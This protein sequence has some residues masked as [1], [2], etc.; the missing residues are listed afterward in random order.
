MVEQLLKYIPTAA[1]RDLLNSHAHEMESFARPDRFL[2]EMSRIPRYS[3]RLKSL[4][5]KKTLSDR[6]D[7]VCPKIEAVHFSCKELKTSKKLRKVLEVVLAFGNFMNR[8][9]RGNA[10]GFRLASLNKMGDT[11]SSSDPDINLL[12][13]LV[14]TLETKFPDVLALETEL[15]H[16]RKASKVDFKEVEKEFSDMQVDLRDLEHELQ[17]Q[18]RS[19]AADSCDL[20]IPVMEEFAA[21]VR[22]VFAG[23]ETQISDTRTEFQKTLLFFGEEPAEVTTEEFFGIFALFLHSFNEAHVELIAVQKKKEEEE[24][25]R[26]EME[27]HK[28]L[29][30][31]RR[32]KRQEA[33]ATDGLDPA[34]R[35]NADFEDK[36]ELD[37]LI[38]V[39]KSGE[40]FS[41]QRGR[42]V[43]GISMTSSSGGTNPRNSRVLEF[44][45]ERSNSSVVSAT[46]SGTAQRDS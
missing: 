29:T 44:S 19:G 14:Q 23:I 12:H 28:Q 20:F 43:S 25:R 41:R 40:Y 11:K 27:R 39:L 15:P 18:R 9:S 8:G 21:N 3:Q 1:E 4:F 33:Q 34:A 22:S 37:D 2:L 31:Q 45:R 13:Y 32:K 6:L 10:S 35:E 24:K 16:I 46:G 42:R 26:G 17:F 5:F 38:A 7:D 30:L 36:A